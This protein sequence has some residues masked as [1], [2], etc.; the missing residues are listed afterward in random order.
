MK[1]HEFSSISLKLKKVNIANLMITGG[2]GPNES[3]KSGCCSKPP[4][5]LHTVTTRPDSL[6]PVNESVD[7]N[8]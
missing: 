1:K 5:C 3:E 2:A 7:R 4:L 8:Q 6:N